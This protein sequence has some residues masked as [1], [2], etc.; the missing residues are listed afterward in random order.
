MHL[1]DDPRLLAL[2]N[3]PPTQD[4][5]RRLIRAQQ[6]RETSAKPLPGKKTKVAKPLPPRSKQKLPNRVLRARARRAKI[7]SMDVSG[8]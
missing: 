6:L 5:L 8:L 2:P 4:E 1:V 7:A 3:E